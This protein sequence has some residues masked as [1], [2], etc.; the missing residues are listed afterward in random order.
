M[1]PD[2]H[3]TDVMCYSV[4]NGDIVVGVTVTSVD[5]YLPNGM[6]VYTKRVTTES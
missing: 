5:I 2:F 6:K 1:V 3:L 4:T